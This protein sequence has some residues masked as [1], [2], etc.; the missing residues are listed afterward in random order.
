M[1]ESQAG[2]HVLASFSGSL[3]ALECDTISA[4]GAADLRGIYPGAET[5]S[6]GKR[7][8]M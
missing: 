6:R 4:R 8:T 7:E 2:L 3:P 5:V 1:I